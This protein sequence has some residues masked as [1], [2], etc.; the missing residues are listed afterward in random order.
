VLISVSEFVKGKSLPSIFTFKRELVMDWLISAKQACCLPTIMA[1]EGYY[2]GPPFVDP[3][4][5]T[6]WSE[7]HQLYTW[8][9]NNVERRSKFKVLQEDAKYKGLDPKRLQRARWCEAVVALSEVIRASSGSSNA[10]RTAPPAPVAAPA[11]S[12]SGNIGGVSSTGSGVVG[13]GF[14]A[15]GAP[16]L[17]QAPLG[18]NPVPGSALQQHNPYLHGL[19]GPTASNGLVYGFPQQDTSSYGSLLPVTTPVARADGNGNPEAPNNNGIAALI[20]M[21]HQPGAGYL[22]PYVSGHALIAGSIGAQAVSSQPPVAPAPS[23]APSSSSSGAPNN[24]TDVAKTDSTGQTPLS[25]APSAPKEEGASSGQSGTA[26][27]PASSQPKPDMGGYPAGAGGRMFPPIPPLRTGAD[28]RP[29]YLM[30]SGFRGMPPPP[31]AAGAHLSSHLIPGT[32]IPY[33]N[34]SNTF[35][36]KLFDLVSTEDETVV[37]WQGHGTSFQVR[38]MDKFVNEILPKHFKRKKNLHCLFLVSSSR[39]YPFFCCICRQ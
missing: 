9:K 39:S 38:N 13:G 30:G 33:R 16:P 29:A 31:G 26:A 21:G 8:W 17:S 5:S 27:P 6:H 18:T 24:F 10:S 19:G 2:G 15:G 14:S 23:E 34:Y 37:G 22:N 32:N 25:P 35:P 11:P 1:E 12:S 3:D 28:G 4:P 7:P 20:H 36:V